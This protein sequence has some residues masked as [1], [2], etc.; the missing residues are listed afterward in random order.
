MQEL[1][2]ATEDCLVYR[3]AESVRAR[4][5]TLGCSWDQVEHSGTLVPPLYSML[6]VM[7]RSPRFDGAKNEF[8]SEKSFPPQR[9]PMQECEP[10]QTLRD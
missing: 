8:L 3:Q 1:M 2:Q 6:G 7:S 9:T 5:A 4:E 10:A